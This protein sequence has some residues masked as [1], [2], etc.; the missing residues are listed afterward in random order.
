MLV[1]EEISGVYPFAYYNF[2]LGFTN[3]SNFDLNLVHLFPITSH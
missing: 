2:G 1:G 3:F